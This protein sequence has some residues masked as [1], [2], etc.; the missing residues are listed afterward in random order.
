MIKSTNEN[1][2]A[3]TVVRNSRRPQRPQK[4]RKSRSRGSNLDVTFDPAPR[5]DDIQML[6][7][8]IK[9]LRDEMADHRIENQPKPVILNSDRELSDE[10]PKSNSLFKKLR[11]EI[12]NLRSD[13]LNLATPKTR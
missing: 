4:L 10:G 2:D 7:E 6:S 8:E 12:K 9:K 3:E 5:N 13:L 1:L 11:N